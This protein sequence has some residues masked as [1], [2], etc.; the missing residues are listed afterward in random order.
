MSSNTFC[1]HLS[2]GYRFYI[3]RG[4][5]TYHPCCQWTGDR[6][7]FD[8][9][10]L[11]QQRTAWN[12]DT[13]WAHMECARCGTEEPYKKD[14]AYRHAGNR[15]I[16]ILPQNKI[17]WLDIQADT[18]CNGGCLICGPWNSSYWQSEITKYQGLV[19]VPNKVD[20][21]ALTNR[22]FDAIDTSELRLLQFLGG[23]PFLSDVDIAGIN[24][25]ANPAQ[26]TL[27]YTTNGSI[28]P[29]SDRIDQWKRFEKVKITLSIDGI[30]ERFDHLRYPLKWAVVENN[31]HRMQNQLPSN[32]E[33]SIN[34]SITPLNIL[35]YDEFLQWVHRNFDIMPKIHCHPAY[36][37]MNPVNGGK[38][39]RDLVVAE[40]GADH[41]LTS[42]TH[43]GAVDMDF[44]EYIDL[45]DSR[46]KTNWRQTFPAVS[47]IDSEK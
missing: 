9:A 30:G 8:P 26:C 16:P 19:S 41:Q 17:A 39:L 37:V 24:R 31:I 3:D 38:I 28:F 35:Y 23:E 36:G 45:W 7:H 32:T 15:Q 25:I 20:L 34:H 27:K 33:F 47:G 43:D 11:D 22:I 18:T 29:K 14:N 2:N 44:L 21:P 1:K 6:V 46:R 42:M 40:Y 12:I 13:P 5:I 4:M 10:T